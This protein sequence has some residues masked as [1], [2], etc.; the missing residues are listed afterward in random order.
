MANLLIKICIKS[1]ATRK[2][3]RKQAP[4][5]LPS[6]MCHTAPEGGRQALP[7]S[8]VVRPQR[9]VRPWGL[10]PGCSSPSVELPCPTGQARHRQRQGSAL[11]AGLTASLGSTPLPKIPSATHC[12]SW[13]DWSSHSTGAFSPPRQCLCPSP[14]SSPVQ[15]E[16]LRVQ[17]GV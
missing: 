2:S 4:A 13:S 1:G 7:V 8:S 9:G 17:R 14:L 5:E 6:H 3:T 10:V 15:T 16:Q 12:P 11:A